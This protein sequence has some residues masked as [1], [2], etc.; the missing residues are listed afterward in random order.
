MTRTKVA[1]LLYLADLRA[2]DELGRPCSGIQWRWRHYGPFSNA[3][4]QVEEELVLDG[5]VQRETCE[6]YWGAEHRLRLHRPEPIEVDEEFAAIIAQVVDEYGHLAASSLRDLTY[7]TP[8]MQEAQRENAR[9]GVLDLFEGRVVPDIGATLARFQSAANRLA[10][11]DDAGDPDELRRE[12]AEW[13]P[14]RAR[15]T[16]E[17]S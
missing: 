13:A 16:D 14:G 11:Q 15:A 8:P 9:E 3:L 5:A 4:L 2:V 12:L 1:K 7:Q 17:L 10:P 6:N